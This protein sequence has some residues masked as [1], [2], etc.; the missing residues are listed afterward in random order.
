[1]PL[2]PSGSPPAGRPFC[3]RVQQRPRARSHR[4][5]GGGVPRS[6]S[7]PSPARARP[8]P[9]H[10]SRAPAGLDVNRPAMAVKIDNHPRARPQT[11][12][13]TADIVYEELVEGG[14]T[15]F[16]GIYHC[17]DAADLGPVR[18]ARAVDPDIM[19]QYAPVLFAYSGSLAEQPGE[20]RPHRRRRSTWRTAPT[21]PP[22]P[23]R[24]AARHPT[25]CTRR[26]TRSAPVRRPRAWRARPRPA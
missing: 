23:A 14:L 15:R 18:S 19:T 10:R 7:A 11:G 6:G 17:G 3:D 9:A 24:A 21:A 16:M 25:T 12:L 4:A 5:V 1:M 20:G 2:T 13:E 22:T 26:P 8:L